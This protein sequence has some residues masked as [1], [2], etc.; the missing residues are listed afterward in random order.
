M[1]VCATTETAPL[2]RIL[3]FK[4]DVWMSEPVP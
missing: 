3:A 4:V 1:D 2:R